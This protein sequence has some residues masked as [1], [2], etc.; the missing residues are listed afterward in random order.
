MASLILILQ[1]AKLPVRLSAVLAR[2]RVIPRSLF[3]LRKI[4]RETFLTKPSVLTP[5]RAS[6]KKRSTDVDVVPVITSP[7]AP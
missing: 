6:R 5:P 2:N 4:R 7:I 1:R 3:A